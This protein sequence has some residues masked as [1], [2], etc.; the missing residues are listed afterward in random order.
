VKAI[1]SGIVLAVSL[2]TGATADPIEQKDLAKHPLDAA[3]G[4]IFLRSPE[5][6]AGT[7]IRIPT[8]SDVAEYRADRAAALAKEKAKYP[9]V[10]DRWQR[11]V[12]W[13]RE[14]GANPQ[15]RPAEPTEKTLAFPSL[16]SRNAVSFGPTFVFAKNP[17]NGEFSYLTPVKPGTYVWYGPVLLDIKQGYLGMCYCM[18]SVQFEVKPGAITDLGDFLVAAPRYDRQKTAPPVGIEASGGLTGFKV[19]LPTVSHEPS[20]GLPAS[21]GGLP[22]IRPQFSAAGKMDNFYGVM[23][24]RLP[25]IEGVLDYRRDK[26]VDVATGQVLEEKALA[27]M[28]APHA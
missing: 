23:I 11:D 13:A 5:R 7:F 15:P 25:P 4:Y 21:L 22:A 12:D 20:F 3:Q 10:L 2:T 6:L 9:K 27:A 8:D 24:S 18:G 19:I 16:E 28:M 14:H 26:V 17:S 1:I